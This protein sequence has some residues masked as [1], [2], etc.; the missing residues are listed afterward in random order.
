MKKVRI[1]KT[2]FTTRETSNLTVQDK[3]LLRSIV[4]SE[5]KR[6]RRANQKVV[7]GGWSGTGAIG[8]GIIR[9][10]EIRE[11]LTKELR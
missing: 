11:S 6:Y 8:H 9:L 10:T 5:L 3:R 1:G 2:I 4:S 7:R